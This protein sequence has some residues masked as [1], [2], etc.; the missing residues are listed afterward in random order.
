MLF[1]LGRCG[2]WW[3]IRLRRYGLP[4]FDVQTL[5]NCEHLL[6]LV[7][8]KVPLGMRRLEHACQRHRALISDLYC[9][10]VFEHCDG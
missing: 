3:L 10:F 5:S 2:F 7:G 1:L 9:E 8:M 6:I 4:K